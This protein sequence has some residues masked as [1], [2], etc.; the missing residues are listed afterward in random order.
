MVQDALD[1]AEF[2]VA[3]A[4]GL[5]MSIEDAIDYALSDVSTP[6]GSTS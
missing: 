1:S 5:E 2:D 3:W 6:T 4:E